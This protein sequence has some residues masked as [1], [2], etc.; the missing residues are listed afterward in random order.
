MADPLKG[1]SEIGLSTCSLNKGPNSHV[2]Q[3]KRCDWRAREP[4]HET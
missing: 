3:A 2:S 1:R 4:A